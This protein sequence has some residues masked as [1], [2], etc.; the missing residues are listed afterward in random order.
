MLP[1]IGV[2]YR[3][4]NSLGAFQV[5]GFL[6][7]GRIDNSS[8]EPIPS[9][10]RSVSRGYFDTNGRWQLGPAWTITESLRVATDKTVTRR[11][12][13]TNDDRLRNLVNAER[14]TS[15]SYVSIAAWAFQG[16]RA[17]D[18]QKTNPFA[19]PAIDARFRHGGCRRWAGADSGQ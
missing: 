19:L 6:T 18:R 2:Q 16:L 14:I 4:L 1:A 8:L 9:T 13:L 15:D 17:D 5:G 7:Y 11:Y 10:P 12:D 3:E